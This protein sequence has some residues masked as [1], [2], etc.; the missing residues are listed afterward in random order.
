MLE[1]PRIAHV[2]LVHP[3]RAHF[4]LEQPETP[5]LFLG[6]QVHASDDLGLPSLGV[7]HKVGDRVDLLPPATR[8]LR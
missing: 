7:D 2:P 5:L 3:G 4:E 6:V 8:G 1:V